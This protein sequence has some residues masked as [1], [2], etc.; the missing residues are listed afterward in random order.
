MSFEGKIVSSEEFKPWS[1]RGSIGQVDPLELKFSKGFLRADFKALLSS[2][3]SLWTPFFHMLGVD[4]TAIELSSRLDFP[5]GMGRVVPIE[6]DGEPGVLA[7]DDVS[8]HAILSSICPGVDGQGADVVLEYLERRFLSALAVTIQRDPPVFC[9]YGGGVEQRAIDV[10]GT[11]ELSLNLSGMPCR[12]YVGLGKRVLEGIDSLWRDY[13]LK[14]GPR[15]AIQEEEVSIEIA[16]LAVPPALLIDYLKAD[17]TIELEIPVS[18]SVFLRMG[19]R[20]W[21]TGQLLQS[22]GL[23]AVRL[24]NVFPEDVTWPEATTRVHIEIAR[25]Y[26][27]ARAIQ[28]LSQVGAVFVSDQELSDSGSMVISREKVADAKVGKIGDRFALNVLPK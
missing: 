13:I 7:M 16:T 19:D 5:D 6:I 21:A 3:S 15:S 12:I 25:K 26:L 27:D 28:E 18:D 14:S 22:N 4:V 23:F 2:I 9:Y 20:L 24:T 11:V 8:Q 17:T 1:P 10:V